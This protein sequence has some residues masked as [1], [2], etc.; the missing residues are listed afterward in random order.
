MWKTG[1]EVPYEKGRRND[2]AW[3]GESPGKWEERKG[4]PFWYEADAGGLLRKCSTE[5][6]LDYGD[7]FYGNA[8]RCRIAKDELSGKQITDILS[9]C[10]EYV[11]RAI[12]IVKPKAI[13]VLGDFA[14]RQVLKKSGI[15]KQRGRWVWSEEFKCWVL[16]V[17]HPAH[18]LRHMGLRQRLVDDFRLVR[19]FIDAD[20]QTPKKDEE[21]VK[22]YKEL[23]SFNGLIEKWEKKEETVGL[24]TECQGKDWLDPNFLLISYSLSPDGGKAFDVTLH[25]E[26]KDPSKP[27]DF[28]I[29]WPRKNGSKKIEPTEV[30][31]KKSKNFKEKLQALAR[32]LSSLKIKKYLMSGNSDF[33][34]IEQGFKRERMT[35]PEIKNYKMDI[36]AAANLIDENLFK[37]SS[38]EELQS[39]FTDVREDYKTEFNKKYNI[40]DMLSVPKEARKEYA[41]SDADVTRRVGF[42]IKEQLSKQENY[43]LAR[44]LARFTMPALGFLKMLETNGALIDRDKLPKVTADVYRS[45]IAA[46][47]RALSL[48]PKKVLQD[49]DI[50]KAVIAEARKDQKFFLTRDDLVAETLFGNL[51]FGLGGIK[52]TPSKQ[53]WSVDKEVRILLLEQDLPGEA[54]EFVDAYNE[55]SEDHTMWSRYLRGFDK[56]I[57]SDGRIHSSYLICVA[58]NGRTSSR[59]PNLQNNPKRS[60]QAMKIRELIRAAPGYKLVATDS[61]QSELRWA[62]EV[63]NDQALAQIFLSNRD[64]HKEVALDLLKRKDR[65]WNEAKWEKLTARQKELYRRNAKCTNFGTLYGQSPKGFKR[66]AKKEYGLDVSEEEGKEWQEVWFNKFSGIR[67]YYQRTIQFGLKYGYVESLLGR[68][69]RLPELRSRDSFVRGNAE[70]MAINHPISSPS[71]DTVILAGCETM[72]RVKDSKEIRPIL[73]THDENVFE[74]KESQVE[75]WV[76]IIEHDMA[77]PPLERDFHFKMRVP[78]SG[79]AKVGENLADLHPL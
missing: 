40:S 60:R 51:G 66:F 77:N 64:P 71:S 69:R 30:H 7:F 36:Q 1:I 65:S 72:K 14:L 75:K 34:Y 18:I 8:A 70:R 46:E 25:E 9:C 20:Y 24:D 67:P 5:V 35:V 44:Y 61:E 79:D 23:D 76:K 78:L 2:V 33:H 50:S 10:R 41:C 28:L 45:M 17:F 16:P 19:E 73:F 54:E 42:S 57:R 32:I 37:M 31:V 48:I 55:F 62:A 4:K 22:Q 3:F 49:F 58:V 43:R 11:G 59:D 27:F 12:N 39:S 21:R 29:S 68:R 15:T 47:D 38:L 26:V 6:G 74:V 63:S 13:V 56:H 53:G 52:R